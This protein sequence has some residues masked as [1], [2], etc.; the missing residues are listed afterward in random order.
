M[1]ELNLYIYQGI[2]NF[3][4]KFSKDPLRIKADNRNCYNYDDEG[5]EDYKRRRIGHESDETA[6]LITFGLDLSDASDDY[7]DIC[8]SYKD[9][10]D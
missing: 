10:D 7:N 3:I 2:N 1:K 8:P 6:G 5:P 4:S 9:R